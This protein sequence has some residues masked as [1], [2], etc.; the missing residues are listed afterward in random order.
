M[1]LLYTPGFM[2]R[3]H[4]HSAASSGDLAE[5]PKIKCSDNGVT[6]RLHKVN[7]EAIAE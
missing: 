5:P 2:V 3:N 4:W 1:L 6:C 7:Y